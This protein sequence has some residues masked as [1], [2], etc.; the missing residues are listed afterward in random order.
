MKYNNSSMGQLYA[1]TLLPGLI[2]E[3]QIKTK[4]LGKG[5]L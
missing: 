1:V 5:M 3:T 4:R 2:A